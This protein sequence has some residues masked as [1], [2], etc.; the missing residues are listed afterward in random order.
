MAVRPA[1]IRGRRKSPTRGRSTPIRN[2]LTEEVAIQRAAELAR[3][4]EDAR[5][6]RRAL[7]A[8]RVGLVS[9]VRALLMHG[10]R[11]GDQDAAPATG[12]RA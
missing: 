3:A 1:E 8:R 2:A 11:A 6:A 9:E 10:R 12:R 4:A 7:H 5:A